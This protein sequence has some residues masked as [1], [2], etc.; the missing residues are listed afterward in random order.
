MT[1]LS[2][3]CRKTRPRWSQHQIRLAKS[4]AQ[5]ETLDVAGSIE[6]LTDLLRECAHKRMA[7]RPKITRAVR[8][9]LGKAHYYATSLLKTSGAAEEEWRPFAER[10][11][12][13]FRFL[14]EHQEPGALQKYEDAWRRSLPRPS[15]HE[16]IPSHIIPLVP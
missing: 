14:A 7:R 8:E 2:A 10:T 1:K 4:K 15:T 9:M 11:R 6:E 3:S 12:Q 16:D 5:L 13:I